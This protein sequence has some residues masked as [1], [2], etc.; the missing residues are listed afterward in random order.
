MKTQMLS[1]RATAFLT[2]SIRQESRLVSHHLMRGGLAVLI[3]ALFMMQL[4]TSSMFGAAGSRFASS[5]VNSFYWF[6][7]IVGLLYYSVAITEEKEEETL[8]LL[9]MTGVSNFALLIGKSMPRLAVAALFVLVVSPFMVLSITMGGVVTEQLVSCLLGLICYSFLLSQL[10]LLASTVAADARRAFTLALILWFTFELG[11]YLVWAFAATMSNYGNQAL[12]GFLEDVSSWWS[13][14]SLLYNL[15]TYLMSDRGDP[16]WF[17]QMTWHLVGG[18]VCFLLSWMLFETF[19]SRAIGQGQAPDTSHR[20]LSIRRKGS[21]L[22]ARAGSNALAWKSWHF[23]L[24]GWRWIVLRLIGLPVVVVSIVVAISLMIR[25]N[26]P[27]EAI[28]VTLMI[29]GVGVLIAELARSL[30]RVLNEEIFRQTMV[31]LKMI[32]VSTSWLVGSLVT[33]VLPVAFP[34]AACF[35]LGFLVFA[36][37][38]P[39]D[40]GDFIEFWMEPWAWHLI[41]WVLLTLQ[42]GVLLSTFLRYGGMVI[43]AAM[44]WIAAPILFGMFMMTI[45]SVFSGFNGPGEVFA[46]YLLPMGLLAAELVLCVV[47]QQMILKRVDDVVQR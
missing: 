25:E 31:S 45:G 11:H 36:A 32:P 24:G 19:N 40:A 29:T 4:A 23:L 8:P 37:A 43:S 15:G 12:A 21:R 18:G 34:A 9:R 16:V 46:R 26:P 14:R 13:E 1:M 2:R 39:R 35:F 20:L 27:P 41:S 10:G 44:L 5:I 22:S 33:G 6:M 7:T 3:M 30:G 42:L 47:I 28:G 38:E 17:P